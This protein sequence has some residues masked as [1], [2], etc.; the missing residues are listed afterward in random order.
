MKRNLLLT[1]II[2]TSLNI[3][4]QKCK[5]YYKNSLEPG[6]KLIS[7]TYAST[8]E[9]TKEGKYIFKRYY[10][11]TKAI[12]QFA[13]SE[14]KELKALHGLYKEFWDDGTLVNR[15]FYKNNV[16]QGE[17]IENETETG[18]YKDGLKQGLWMKTNQKG[19]IIEKTHYVNGTVHGKKIRY[20]SLGQ[21]L[22]T[23]VFNGGTLTSS[24]ADS[25]KVLSEVMPR[26]PGCEEEGLSEI[27][28]ELCAKKKMLNYIYTTMRYPRKALDERVQ[29]KA[30]VKFTVRKDGTIGNI[31]TL[32][33]LCKEIEETVTQIVENMPVWIPG[34]KD[35][36]PVDVEYTLPVKFRFE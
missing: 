11:D 27:D 2:I 7:C 26:Y 19:I 12:T 18:A 30:I 31:K 34:Y 16:K 33:G 24:T 8:F 3:H 35:G 5:R 21:E 14:T 22:Y 32:S 23:E 4:A 10:P 29:G 17:W 6:S 20:D 28:R 15:G 1:L 25:T 36:K 13:T 9:K